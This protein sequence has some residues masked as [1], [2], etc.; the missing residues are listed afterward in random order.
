MKILIINTNDYYGD[1][2][3]SPAFIS[4]IKAVLISNVSSNKNGDDWRIYPKYN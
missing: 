1:A 3:A 4:S 2:R